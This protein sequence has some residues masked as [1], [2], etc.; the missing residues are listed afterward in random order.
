MRCPKCQYIS[1]DNGERCRNCGYEFSLTPSVPTSDLPIQ[2]GDEAFGPLA[3]FALEVAPPAGR[4]EASL[5]ADTVASPPS[6]PITSSFDLPLFKERRQQ[7]DESTRAPALSERSGRRVEGPALSERSGRRVEGP[8]PS[9][10]SG[11]RVEGPATPRPP[12]SVRRSAPTPPRS[13]SRGPEEQILGF[14]LDEASPSLVMRSPTPAAIHTED[15][16]RVSP[17]APFGPRILAAFI[18]MGI[19]TAI[20]GI[21]LYLTLSIC[22]VPWSRVAVIPWVPFGGF[23]VL[24]AGGYFTLFTAA[25]GQTIGKMA[26]GIKVVPVD[27]E[28]GRVPLGHSVLRATAYVVSAMPAGLGFLPVLFGTD[29]RAIHDRLAETRVVKA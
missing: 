27:R 10:R 16:D 6:R 28:H 11:A 24:I 26:A 7:P 15:N 22:G 12:L 4:H 9:E 19:L 2:T 14:G 3:D 13:S 5:V 25:G 8:A 17:T 20:A 18:D 21:V 29:K 23:L 1:F